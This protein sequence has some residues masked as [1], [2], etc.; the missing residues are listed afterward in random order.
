[1]YVDTTPAAG[2]GGGPCGVV[3]IGGRKGVGR[4]EGVV[5]G[6]LTAWLAGWLAGGVI[7]GRGYVQ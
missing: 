4:G 3:W 1:M 2:T 6:W 5:T 7:G